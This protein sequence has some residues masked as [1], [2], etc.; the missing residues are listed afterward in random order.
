MAKKF[1]DVFFIKWKTD[2][3][4]KDGKYLVSV[5]NT[6]SRYYRKPYTV[7]LDFIRG[8]WEFLGTYRQVV[9]WCE[10]KKPCL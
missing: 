4:T 1:H 6:N 5:K 7:I 9:A 10:V 2:P 8:Q 3:P